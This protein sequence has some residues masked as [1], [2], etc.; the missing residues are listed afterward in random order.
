MAG[1][2]EIN[3]SQ[4]TIYFIF[5][6]HQRGFKTLKKIKRNSVH[7]RVACETCNFIWTKSCDAKKFR[8][9]CKNSAFTGGSFLIWTRGVRWERGRHFKDWPESEWGRLSMTGLSRS[10]E[11]F[12]MTDLS[13]SGEG[14][15]M[16][17]LSQRPPMIRFRFCLYCERNSL[18][19]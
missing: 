6:C 2:D 10:G 19:F 17:G 1:K 8:P 11:I 12:S 16:T 4:R 9:M 18:I 13:R 15:S 14:F 7:K 3:C 5:Q